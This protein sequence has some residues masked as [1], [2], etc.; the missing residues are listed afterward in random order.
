MDPVV[1]LNAKASRTRYGAEREG[2]RRRSLQ[3]RKGH[4]PAKK[5]RGKAVRGGRDSPT[6][7]VSDSPEIHDG[8]F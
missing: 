7:K 1:D 3:A 2:P 5:P 6:K 8:M 4:A